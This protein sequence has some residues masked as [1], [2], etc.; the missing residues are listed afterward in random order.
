MLL[1]S[2][3]EKRERRK[4]ERSFCALRQ[5]G[6]KEESFLRA[7]RQVTLITGVLNCGRKLWGI[8]RALLSCD[9]GLSAKSLRG[10]PPAL[11]SQSCRS[12]SS[13]QVG[14][15][16]WN[17]GKSRHPSF[18][19]LVARLWHKGKHFWRINP[20]ATTLCPGGAAGELRRVSSAPGVCSTPC[21][22]TSEWGQQREGAADCSTGVSALIVAG[23]SVIGKLPVGSS[24]RHLKYFNSTSMSC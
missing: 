20:L 23:F 24:R 7:T 2:L 10:A 14:K 13:E 3:R 6:K 16:P 21:T 8:S 4:A 9:Q 1:G 11:T 19:G 22:D 12:R 18:A 17:D 15:A 5:L